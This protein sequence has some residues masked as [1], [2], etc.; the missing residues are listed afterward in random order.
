MVWLHHQQKLGLGLRL[1][2]LGA[3]RFIWWIDTVCPNQFLEICFSLLSSFDDTEISFSMTHKWPQASGGVS[4][5]RVFQDWHHPKASYIWFK[6][7]VSF[8]SCSLTLIFA[9]FVPSYLLPAQQKWWCLNTALPLPWFSA[10]SSGQLFGPSYVAPTTGAT[11]S[12]WSQNYLNFLSLIFSIIFPMVIYAQ[13]L[14]I[15]TKKK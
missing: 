13:G 12:P 7:Q 6:S 10:R 4:K 1:G 5:E 3:L 2:K 14:K 8:I 9:S 15:K 11:S